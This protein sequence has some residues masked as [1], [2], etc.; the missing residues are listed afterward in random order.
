MYTLLHQ[1]WTP[2]YPRLHNYILECSLNA[3]I[4]T[5]LI[6]LCKANLCFFFFLFITYEKKRK[7]KKQ[8]RK[9]PKEGSRISFLIKT[10]IFICFQ[11]NK[12]IYI[13]LSYFHYLNE[14]I[15]SLS[16]KVS[17]YS[18]IVRDKTI[19]CTF[20]LLN[21][22]IPYIQQQKNNYTHS[23]FTLLTKHVFNNVGFDFF[24]IQ[25]Y[26]YSHSL[27]KHVD[28]YHQIPPPLFPSP[29]SNSLHYFKEQISL[30]N[31]QS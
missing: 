23:N 21:V 31:F 1:I 27:W 2:S 26:T 30:Y 16:I 22:F 13:I 8:L 24:F 18:R 20:I 5:Y 25:C 9:I 15:F 12:H 10:F 7:E 14:F 17:Q 28:F 29:V 3:S 11:K 6:F 19:P 4:Y